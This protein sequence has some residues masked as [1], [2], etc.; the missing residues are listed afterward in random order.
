VTPAGVAWNEAGQ[1][2]DPA[3]ALLVKLGFTYVPPENLEPERESLRDAVSETRL[4]TALSKLNPWLSDDNLHKAVRTITSVQ[5]STLMEANEKLFAS[6]FAGISLDQD[7]GAGKKGQQVRFFDFEKA[8]NNEFLVT[9][10]YRVKGNKKHIVADVA[11]LVNGIPLVLIECKN[12]TLG[13]AWKAEALEQLERYQELSAKFKELGA[14]RLFQTVQLLVATCG[15]DAV[16]GTIGTPGRDFLRWKE[17]YPFSA[18]QVGKLT[19][20]DEPNAQDVTLAGLCSPE[21]LLDIARNFVAFERDVHSGKVIKKVPRY[22]QFAAVNKALVRSRR[23]KRPE[24]RGGVVWHTQG[25]GKSLTMLWLAQ[26]LRRDPLHENPTLVL[27]TDRRDLDDQITK[28]FIACGF[29]NPVRAESIR[30][31]REILQGPSGSTVMTTV[32]KFQEIGGVSAGGKRV[33]KQKHPILTEASNVFVLTD[34]AHRTQYGSLA[35]NL[36]MALPNAVFF[37]FTGTPIDKQDR[38]TLVTF[39][40]YID[41]YTI[42]QAVADEATVPIFYESRLAELQIIG[43]SLDQIF[44]RV[45]ADRSVDERRA[46]KQKY[47]TEQVLAEA[48]R[49]IEAICLDIID[50]YGKFIAPN[51]FKAQ[52]VVGS[53]RAAALYK[54]QL[55]ALHGPPSAVVMSSAHNE[56]TELAKHATSDEDRKQIIENFPKK[57]HPLKFLIV[58]DMLLT[59]FDAP[60][61]QV[62]YLDKALKE[63]TLLQAIARVNRT[64]ENKKYG[65]VVDYWG[66]STEL[67]EALAIFSPSDIKGALAPK[68]DELPRLQARHAAA[69]RFFGRVKDKNDL[70]RCVATLDSEDVRAEFNTAFRRFA[71][72][73]DMMLPDPKALDYASDLGWLGK[74]RLAAKARYRDETVDISDCGDKVRKL[75]EDSVAASGVQILVKAVNI[76]SGEFETKLDALKSAEAKA[77]EMEHAVRHEIHVKLEEDPAYYQSLRER[78]EQIIEDRKQARIDAAEQLSRLQGLVDD[79]R[80]HSKAA[81]AEGLSDTGY[82]IYGLLKGSQVFGVSETRATYGSD[83][84]REVAAAIEST[85]EP[86]VAIVDWTKKSDVQ[87]EMRRLI[88]RRLPSKMYEETEQDRV[89]EAMVDLLKVRKKR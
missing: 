18:A 37:G 5:A 75:I 67:Q 65:L 33:H 59:G 61:E 72:S 25:S 16:Y 69:I 9:R 30:E 48:P 84:V 7:L 74:I 83:Q 66:V 58:C 15:Q 2:E 49:R 89:A 35:A 17:P 1:S 70:D 50:H 52:I 71:E 46:I 19:G 62:M 80:G 81:E 76:F 44:E 3:V 56:D 54:E 10:Q 53:R 45:F 55:D 42:E 78:L 32:Q 68:H 28:T 79:L 82:A 14:P 43:N 29:P 34:E 39:G 20:K 73:M 88:K 8:Q 63:H 22:Q 57:D 64:A 40:S 36:R 77:S 85:I 60:I 4:R 23:G 47:A 11:C 12:P 86:Q 21:N 26:K 41:Q 13:D 6:L 38:S 51:G 24:D 87:R 31:L 27:V